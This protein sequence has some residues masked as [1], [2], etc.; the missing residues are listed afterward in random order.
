MLKKRFRT[1]DFAIAKCNLACQMLIWQV[2]DISDRSRENLIP[3]R[4][5]TRA[6]SPRKRHT[7]FFHWSVAIVLFVALLGKRRYF[8][9]DHSV[10]S[11][12]NASLI[13]QDP[14]AIEGGLILG[15]IPFRK[16]FDSKANQGKYRDKRRG[17]K[18]GE[19]LIFEQ[20]CLIF[21][22]AIPIRIETW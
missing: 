2:V 21:T 6:R 14:W 4:K 8:S 18:E 7:I 11:A 16:S 15:R 10:D 5:E 12:T 19:C 22:H 20:Q 3:F 17:R 1:H 13:L 9:I